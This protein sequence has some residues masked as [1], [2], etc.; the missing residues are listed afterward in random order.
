MSPRVLESSGSRNKMPR[1][2]LNS[3]RMSHVG[4]TSFVNTARMKVTAQV[5]YQARGAGS[6]PPSLDFY[7]TAC[8]IF[9]ERRA[10]KCS[11]STAS[12]TGLLMQTAKKSIQISREEIKLSPT[13]G[14]VTIPKVC[15]EASGIQCCQTALSRQGTGAHTWHSIPGPPKR[16]KDF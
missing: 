2:K 9:L 7:N 10:V 13:A 15:K 11:Y 14:K 16:F 3:E 4:Q 12:L 5:C 8:Q 6:K 1:L